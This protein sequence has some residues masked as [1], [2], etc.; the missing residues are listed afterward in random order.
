MIFNVRTVDIWTATVDGRDAGLARSLEA[1]SMAGANLEF[2]HSYRDPVRPG[3]VAVWVTPLSTEQQVRA[4]EAIGFR[5]DGSMHALRLEGPDQPGLGYLVTR[6]LTLAGISL[7]GL[8]V[9]VIG[10]RSIML[11][12]FETAADE[13]KA[14]ARLNL[15]V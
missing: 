6:A 15:P 4:A 13:E 3:G 7:V 12:S 1:L 10:N 8:S 2:I 14:R 11:L 9:A 5:R